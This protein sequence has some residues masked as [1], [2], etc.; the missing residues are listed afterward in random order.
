MKECFGKLLFFEFLH[1]F[2]LK[3]LHI[4]FPRNFENIPQTAASL[5]LQKQPSMCV[6]TVAVLEAVENLLRYVSA[7]A[8][9]DLFVKELQLAYS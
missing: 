9:L 1:S 3:G 5:T 2:T 6:L 8:H 4:C 7:E